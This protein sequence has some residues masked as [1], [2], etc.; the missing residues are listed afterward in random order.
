MSAD[1]TQFLAELQAEVLDRS[2]GGD[3]SEPDFRENVFTEYV[4]ELLAAEIGIVEGASVVHFLGEF[5]RGR[6]KVNGYALP[7]EAGEGDTI[8]I[9]ASVY[10]GFNAVTRIKNEEM[11]L[12]AEQAMRYLAGALSGLHEKMEPAT[13]QYDMTER[14]HAAGQKLRK[15]RLFVLTD[16]ETDLARKKPVT[17]SV[18]DIEVKLEFWDIERLARALAYGRPQDE[19]EIDLVALNGGGLPCVTATTGAVDYSAYVMIVPGELIFR[20]YEE[21]GA[22]LLERNVRSFLQARGKVNRGIRDTLREEPEH[23]LAYNNGISMTAESVETETTSV[24]LAVI[25]IRGLQVVNGGQTTASIHRA[26]KQDKA[27]LSRVFVQAK[28]TVIKQDLLDALAPKIAEFANTQNPIQ[29]ADFSANDPFHIEIERLSNTIWTPDQQGRW[30]YERARGQYF[31]AQSNEG[32]TDARLRRF[33]ERTPPHRKF[34]KI[35]LAKFMNAWDQLPHQVSA[36]GQK[37]FVNFTQRLRE[38]KPKNWKPDD[39]FYR[40]LIA[41]AIVFNEVARIV[42]REDFEGYRANIVAYTVSLLAFR[43]GDHFDLAHVWNAQR[44]S[45]ELEDVVR[46]W[47][48]SV[49]DAIV[50]AAGSRNISEW[51]KKADCWKQIQ[52]LPFQWPDQMPRELTRVVREGGGWGIKPNEIRVAVDPEDM[53]ASRRCRELNPTDWIRILE[54]G[55]SSGRL[56]PNQ[57]ELVSDIATLAAGGW[58]KE[59]TSKR[60][61]EGRSIIN[62]ALESG[63]L[64]SQAGGD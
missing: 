10:R 43:S 5:N 29:M 40:K 7:D 26:H 57:R 27:D 49:A 36:G 63:V 53:D 39:T 21:Y 31:V 47:S 18:K 28:L 19:I 34:T 59:L 2:T 6:A 54:W 46:S 61:R 22:R 12:A 44:L 45:I 51:C 13:D 24:G 52:K 32:N 48:H 50:Q 17:T 35:D 38:S 9:F 8:D 55:T 16:G 20:L 58:V 42:K 15:A 64:E 25:R 62:A 14:I 60:A 33:R 37:N 30:F 41:K 56:D 23:F 3:G 1:A 11:Q 4:V